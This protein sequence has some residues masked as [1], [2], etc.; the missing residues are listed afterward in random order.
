[1]EPVIRHKMERTF[2][3]VVDQYMKRCPRFRRSAAATQFAYAR[4]LQRAAS[5]EMLG[6]IDVDVLAPKHIYAYLQSLSPFHGKARMALAAIRQV[7]RWALREELLPNAIC[8]AAQDVISDMA[9]DDEDAGHIPWTDEQVAHAI[10]VARPDLARAIKLGAHTGQ[11][12]SDLIKM[13]WRDLKEEGGVLGVHVKQKKTGTRLWVPFTDADFEEEVRQWQAAEGGM[14]NLEGTILTRMDGRPW[15]RKDLSAHWGE[16][17]KRNPELAGYRNPPLVIHGLRGYRCVTLRRQGVS[18]MNISG[19]VGLT[20][21]MVE[22][23]CRF[24]DKTANA[25]ATVVLLNPGRKKNTSKINDLAK[26]VS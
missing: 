15:V 16:E 13:R 24:S 14:A 22:R 2:A 4:E 5:F 12:G 6:A 20:T 17:R 10:K 21:P 25:L 26:T 19:L 11:R 9:E 1:L 7:E 23:Y 18:A 8:V 3:A